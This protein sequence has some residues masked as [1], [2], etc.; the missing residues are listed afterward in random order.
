[1]TRHQKRSTFCTRTFPAETQSDRLHK[2]IWP[3]KK[4]VMT[5]L[6]ALK[7]LFVQVTEHRRLKGALI[8]LN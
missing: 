1:M 6:G 7:Q 3:V 4:G 2:P 5:Q 8:F